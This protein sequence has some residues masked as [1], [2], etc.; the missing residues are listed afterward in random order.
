MLTPTVDAEAE[1]AKADAEALAKIKA[2]RKRIEAG[3]SFADV[4]KEVS[5]DTGSGAEGGDLGWF[6]RGRMVPEFEEAAFSLEPGK[7]SEPIKTQFGYHLIFV[8]EK[9]P[10]RP[11]EETELE[12][13]RQ[14]AFTAW[15]AT[16]QAEAAIERN[17]SVDKVPALP[18]DIRNFLAQLAAASTQPNPAATIV[19]ATPAID[20][21]P[22]L[23]PSAGDSSRQVTSAFTAKRTITRRFSACG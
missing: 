5:E 3:E 11:V 23:H 4:A 14:E 18:A 7:V 13:R 6:A 12:Q 19:V 1:A 16:Q 17:W 21:T 10:E 9:D 22:S 8:E 2:I 15:L 20:I